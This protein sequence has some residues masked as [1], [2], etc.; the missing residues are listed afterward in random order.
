MSVSRLR[1]LVG[2]VECSDL[3][4]HLPETAYHGLQGAE[5]IQTGVSSHEIPYL[6]TRFNTASRH[7]SPKHRFR[8]DM[9]GLD[10]ERGRPTVLYLFGLPAEQK[11]AFVQRSTK[12]GIAYRT[13]LIGMLCRRGMDRLY[14]V[15][16][17][18]NEEGSYGSE[19]EA[20][21]HPAAVD[22]ESQNPA[23]ESG[24]GRAGGGRMDPCTVS[25][26]H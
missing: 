9:L 1:N 11:K 4:F 6:Q 23:T 22:P 21:A 26:V 8:L 2:D 17:K 20:A 24:S 3:G 19:G 12:C 25:L 15:T 14:L 7:I 5:S 13:Y 18:F 16:T 10:S